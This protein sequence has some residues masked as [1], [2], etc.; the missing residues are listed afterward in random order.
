MV[1]FD[2][3]LS[4]HMIL[5]FKI[6]WSKIYVRKLH[7]HW[8]IM[9]PYEDVTLKLQVPIK[10]DTLVRYMG[11]GVILTKDNLLIYFYEYNIIFVRM[12]GL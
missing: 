6:Y 11:L 5:L 12:M 4:L 1:L 9:S 8:V 3:V 10:V 7:V 2:K